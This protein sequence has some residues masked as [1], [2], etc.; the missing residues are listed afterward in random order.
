MRNEDIYSDLKQIRLAADDKYAIQNLETLIRGNYALMLFQ[1]IEEAKCEL[2]LY[3]KSQI[4][5]ENGELK[6]KEDIARAEFEKIIEGELE[7]IKKCVDETLLNSGL[8]GKEIDFVFLTGGT[9]Y[10]PSIKNIFAGKF[11]AEKIKKTDAFTSVAY[12]LGLS[13]HL[14]EQ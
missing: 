5:Y 1:A 2:S 9:S 4:N 6:I 13:G 11:G 12:G 7:K 3:D 10:I 14:F 8:T